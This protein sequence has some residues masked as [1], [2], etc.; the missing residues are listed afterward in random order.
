MENIKEMHSISLN[1]CEGCCDRRGLMCL[2]LGGYIQY[3]DIF[4][5]CTKAP[6]YKWKVS[7][8]SDTSKSNLENCK[9]GPSE[10]PVCHDEKNFH[11]EHSVI[12]RCQCGALIRQ[13]GAAVYAGEQENENSIMV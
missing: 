3:L 12:Y 7:K 13:L 9:C 6:S 8:Y 4:G 10:C 11:F 5:L 1:Q 2:T